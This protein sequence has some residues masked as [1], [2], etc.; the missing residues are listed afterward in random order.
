MATICYGDF[1]SEISSKPAGVARDFYIYDYLL[2]NNTSS[3]QTLELYNLVSNKIPKIMELIYPR[4]SQDSMPKEIF[5]KRLPYDKLIKSDDECLNIGFRLSYALKNQIPKNVLTRLNSER[6][7]KQIEI[8]KSK[9]ILNTL[10]KERG[11]EFAEFFVAF[12]A[13]SIFNKPIKDLKSLDNKNFYKSIYDIVISNK[14]PKFTKSLLEARVVNTNDY[15]MLGLGLN[16]LK[17][18]S[19]KK[20]LYYF[21]E[22]AKQSKSNSI[23][24]HAVFWQYR[25]T[26][27]KKYLELLSQSS[28]FNLFSLYGV[29]ALKV[30]PNFKVL[31]EDSAIFKKL[32][33]SSNTF[34]IK[35][36][37]EWQ[38]IRDNISSIEDK[39]TL[40]NISKLFYYQD[41]LPHLIYVLNKYYQYKVNF[42]LMPYVSLISFD[43]NEIKFL[44]YAIARQESLFLPAVIS[45][46]YALGMMQIMPFNVMNFAKEQ[47]LL[48]ITLESMFDPK[49]A[50]EFGRYYIL[51]LQKRLKHP[52]F[53]SYAYNGGPTFF[54]KY[55]ASNKNAFSRNGKYEPWLSMEF[56][57][58][59]ESRIYG[60][61]VM[62]NYIMYNKLNG[63][64]INIDDFMQGVLR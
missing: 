34:N 12:G 8:I 42:F 1:L 46:S 27:Q 52:L 48:D 26:G 2:N 53:I 56:V 11:E 7:K 41:T 37:F 58:Y 4:I 45:R 24:D 25:I 51:Y 10:L 3:Q 39:E 43:S 63:I 31:R 49:N 60:I 5:C 64:E 13:K 59:E 38:A 16:E 20:A 9:D 17:S 61:K 55:L 44:T 14:Y 28:D 15:T 19:S 6:L 47:K 18:G 22:L 35:D 33:K 30:E 29:E 36:P 32:G 62:A 21:S 54:L 23:R 50:L 40:L 57:P